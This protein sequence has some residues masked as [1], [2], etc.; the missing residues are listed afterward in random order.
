[1]LP[2]PSSIAP[3]RG[4]GGGSKLRIPS[5]GDQVARIGPVFARLRAMLEGETTSGM[6]LRQDPSS[7]S[8]DRVIVFEI[9]GSV[10]AF[11]SAVAKVPGM[12]FMTELDTE[13]APDQRF[14]TIDERKDN[15]GLDLD[16]TD[17]AVGGCY[18]LAM[19]DVGAFSQ[20]LSLW[21]RW[22]EDQPLGYGM[23]S[24]GNVFEQLRTVRPW[25]PQDRIPDETITYWQ[26]EIDRNPIRAVRTEV[27]LW[28]H[29]ADARRRRS[30][31]E[32]RAAVS[33]SDGA[34]IHETIIPEIAYHG[35]LIDI[36]AAQV[37]QLMERNE[38]ALAVADDVMFLRP[39]SLLLGPIETEPLDEIAG[40]S[41]SPAVVS[42]QPIAA[43]LD[44]VPIPN[45]VLLANRLRLDDPDDLQSQAI[46][47]NRIHGT[48]MASLIIHGDI[49]SAEN[50]LTRP[51]YMRPILFSDGNYATEHTDTSRL[52]IDTIHRAIVRIKGTDIEQGEA[53]TVFLVNLSIG[54]ERRP[55]VGV[56]SPLAR[57]LDYLSDAYGILF[58]ISGG[59]VRAPITIHEYKTWDSYKFAD[60]SDRQ[61]ATLDAINAKKHLRTIISPAESLNALTIGAQHNDNFTDRAVPYMAVDPFDDHFLPNVSSGLGLGQRR[62]IKP[63]LFLPGGREHLQL[64]GSGPDGVEVRVAS[65]RGLFGLKA[66][67]P[68]SGGQGRLDQLFLSDG[69]S[70]ATA[71]ATRAG[72]RIFD[73]LMS[74]DDLLA[75]I[76]ADY[77]AVIIK[78]LLVH[79]ARWNGSADLIADICGP[80]DSHRGSERSENVSR[81]MGF[82]VPVVEEAMECSANRATLIGY[83]MLARDGAHNYRIPLPACLETVKEPRGLSLTLAWFSPIT[84]QLKNYR[85][86]KLEARPVDP[87]ETFGVER[88]TTQPRDALV[89]RGSI[90][91][92]HY[93]GNKAVP[94][95]DDGHLAVQVWCRE[96]AG[97]ISR[98][99]RYALAITIEAGVGLP[100]YDEIRNR[101]LIKPLA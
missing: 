38:V 35:V 45:H 65:T 26:E 60:P 91:H 53:P 5:K 17:K 31:T 78:T 100:I 20:L 50:P 92:E 4:T 73:A 58:L 55:F 93:N 25:G 21:E 41:T 79:R 52:L 44:G 54:D 8:P 87:Q 98:S 64:Q 14:A 39:Q 61:R 28:F 43:L 18:Y 67:T 16:R 94:F 47:S 68:D 85:G 33:R 77:Y 80:S 19:P 29:P 30:S 86:V 22:T 2:G 49:S 15:K 9:A 40:S 70:S 81:F 74:D 69:T 66:A 62:M 84:P 11:A 57:L 51:L 59:N 3:P 23:A 27:E 71:L 1:M 46:V 75:N 96:D 32:F 12:E 90:F 56:V 37:Q 48:A 72:H 95:I 63:D 97:Q 42:E 83:G 6:E 7:L 101:L 99:I 76:D 89:K 88:F 34:V 24:F 13:A 82:G 36:P 10:K